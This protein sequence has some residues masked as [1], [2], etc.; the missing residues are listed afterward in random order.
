MKGNNQEYSRSDDTMPGQPL[1]AVRVKSRLQLVL[2]SRFG[3]RADRFL[4]TWEI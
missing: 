3:T 2:Y 1:S 4:K